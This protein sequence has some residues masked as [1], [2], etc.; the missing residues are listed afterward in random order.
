MGKD[1]NSYFDY[2]P[3]NK[4]ANKIALF[5]SDKNTSE[6]EQ[7]GMASFCSDD[8]KSILPGSSIE[9][10]SILDIKNFK[11]MNDMT[12]DAT[13][14]DLSM[15]QE[16]A[17]SVSTQNMKS[18]G[19]LS[20]VIKKPLKDQI[21]DFNVPIYIDVKKKKTTIKPHTFKA[22][23]ITKYEI[24][25]TRSNKCD[26]L[27]ANER[28][29]NISKGTLPKTKIPV[30]K[31][32]DNSSKSMKNFADASTSTNY[33]DV[34]PD[35]QTEY[36]MK[37]KYIEKNVISFSPERKVV[38][39][40]KKNT[41]LISKCLQT[42]SN[43]A[44]KHRDCQTYTIST[45]RRL[46]VRD[47]LVNTEQKY[48][49]KENRSVES[50]ARKKMNDKKIETKKQIVPSKADKCKR[51]NYYEDCKSTRV[52]NDTKIAESSNE[53][54]MSI[55]NISLENNTCG[56]DHG[57]LLNVNIICQFYDD[58]GAKNVSIQDSQ[59]AKDAS[60]TPVEKTESK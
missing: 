9:N 42:E 17:V 33:M 43:E 24:S 55:Q 19:I 37:D 31:K 49:A 6:Y 51:C 44:A 7:T 15:R 40:Q 53:D 5:T 48:K 38:E 54:M 36:Q 12:D 18:A 46:K 13:S 4:R 59:T 30:S 50:E 23:N 21:I 22:V 20:K 26:S 1:E 34:T 58:E 47:N 14:E 41:V 60:E 52:L 10:Y 45:R 16:N 32:Q 29:Q 27:E 2:K 56:K 28:V 25:K 35:D 57:R 39:N 3:E 11:N 8:S